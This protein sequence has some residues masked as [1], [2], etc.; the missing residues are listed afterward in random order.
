VIEWMSANR[1]ATFDLGRST[2]ESG[3]HRFKQKWGGTD[4]SR[5][6]FFYGRD[7]PMRAE[8]MGALRHGATTRQKLWAAMPA[9][10]A[11]AVGPYL[12]R[13]DPIG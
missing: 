4:D 7:A 12:R 11:R 2:P 8:K 13:R 3:V 10:I 9:C 1:V 6:Y 5:R